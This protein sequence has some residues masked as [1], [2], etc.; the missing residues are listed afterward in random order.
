[1][2]GTHGR[3]RAMPLM[4]RCRMTSLPLLLGIWAVLLL[5]GAPPHGALALLY[6]PAR[7]SIWDPSCIRI[8]GKTHCMHRNAHR[9]QPEPE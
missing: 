5:V 9:Q 1:M 6:A 4:G 7:G 3:A 8:G 2:P